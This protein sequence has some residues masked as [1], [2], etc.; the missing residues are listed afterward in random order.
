MFYLQF[1]LEGRIRVPQACSEFRSGNP[2]LLISL[3]L[4][5]VAV[6]ALVTPRFADDID[7]LRKLV[8]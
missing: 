7:R 2:W 1:S 4:H 3:V 6:V 8:F 5:R